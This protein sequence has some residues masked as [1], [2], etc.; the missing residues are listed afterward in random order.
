[1]SAASAGAAIRVA[2]LS[3]AYRIYARPADMLRELVTGRPRHHLL[4]ALDDVSFEVGWGKVLGVVGLNGSGK[5][6]LLKI[7][8]GTLDKTGGEAEVNG[9]LSAILELGTGFHPEYTGRDNVIMG[10]MCLGMSREE[11]GEKLES[12]I[13]FS[14]IRDFIDQP[15]KTYS[16]GMQARLTFATATA[17]DP[18]IFIVDEALA[19]GDAVFVQKCLARMRAICDSGATVLFVSHSSPMVT[20]LCDEAIWLEKG[21]VRMHGSALDVVRAYDYS[22]YEQI[23]E[24]RG[25]TVPAAVVEATVATPGDGENDEP[26]TPPD[27]H[28]PMVFRQ[29]PIVIDEIEFLDEAGNASHIF[30]FWE[31]LRIRVWYHCEGAIPEE[32]LGMGVTFVRESDWTNVMQFNTTNVLRDADFA[33]YDKAPYRQQAGR[34]GYIEACIEPLQLNEGTYAL[35]IGLLANRPYNV[36]CYELHQFTHRVSIARDGSVFNAIFRPVVRW[37]HNPGARRGDHAPR[38]VSTG[39]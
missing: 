25:T 23:S 26:S 2:N 9:S 29:G 15:F 22:I 17:V 13:E 10:G 11:V 19:A 33:D 31:S 27:E 32:T 6:T 1:M 21:R 34:T 24:G 12:I 8:A 5:S 30:R 7:L 18:E 38:E 16:S 35:S 39:G 28:A 20:Q 4:K 14:G 37:E 3:K 36:D